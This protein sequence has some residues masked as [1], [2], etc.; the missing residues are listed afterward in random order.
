MRFLYDLKLLLAPPKITDPVF[1]RL[2]FIHIAKHPERSYWEGNWTFPSTGYPVGVY[3]CGGV[4][5]P[6]EEARE[7]YLSLPD[8]FDQILNLCRPTLANVFR[9][10]LDRDLPNDILGELR[11]AGFGVDDPKKH[12]LR[13]DV[14]FETTGEKWLGIT[15]PFVMTCLGML[16]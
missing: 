14:S 11:L 3:P 15:I 8:R 4:N 7:F 13:W 10:W 6:S 12:P 1:G 9:E 2:T 16:Q 5:G